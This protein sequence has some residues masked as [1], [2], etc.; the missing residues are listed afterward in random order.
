MSFL[1][2]GVAALSLLIAT[3]C[4]TS[5]SSD[6]GPTQENLSSTPLPATARS[7]PPSGVIGNHRKTERCN[8]GGGDWTVPPVGKH[9]EDIS[10]ALAYGP[11]DC[12]KRSKIGLDAFS[13]ASYPCPYVT[14]FTEVGVGV[15]I[16]SGSWTFGG[17]EAKASIVSARFES[18][19]SY[20]IFLEDE[21]GD[22]LYQYLAGKPI[23]GMLGFP[24]PFQN[25][26][27][28]PSGDL[29]LLVCYQ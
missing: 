19:T 16:G 10:G 6:L 20:T 22:V 1:K 14:G 4:G 25:G 2:V 13:A 27:S 5:P 24:S 9:G 15:S 29:S 21:S 23:D 3:S 26:F 18:A 11:S 7:A 12:I 17:T 28:W 8:P